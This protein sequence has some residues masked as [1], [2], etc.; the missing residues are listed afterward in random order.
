MAAEP[1]ARVP[2]W[3]ANAAAIAWRAVIVVAAL[4][5]VGLAFERLKVLIVPLVG[6][7][8]VTTVLGPPASWL[9]RHRV[10]S[11]VATWITILGAAAVVAAIVYGVLPGFERELPQLGRELASGVGKVQVWLIHGPLHLSKATVDAPINRITR[12]LTSNSSRVVQGA[13]SGVSLVASVAV[14]ILLTIVL[15]FFFVKDGPGMGSWALG[16]FSER[17][18]RVARELGVQSW[19]TLTGYI[20]GTAVNGVVN[21]LVLS[22]TMV[23]LGLPFAFPVGLLTFVGGFLP[24]VGGIMSGLLATLVGLVAQGPLAAVI[25]LGATVLVHNLEGYLVG[26]LVLGRA[27]RLH[28]VA[29]L[30]ILGVGAILGGVIGAF[31]A[32]PVAAVIIKAI[33]YYHSGRASLVLVGPGPGPA[34]PDLEG[35]PADAPV[36]R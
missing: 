13:L 15:T 18:R 20:R 11:V 16:L 6:A 4:V 21:G 7:L 36:A 8:F 24:L 27:V 34:R 19:G 12:F 25:M 2:R 29:I 31:L 22:L 3:L 1:S 28:P 14:G 35:L 17:N 33:A 23:G 5:L 9:R 32:V 30:L 26:P 10:P